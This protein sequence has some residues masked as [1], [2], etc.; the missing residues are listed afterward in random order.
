[1][2]LGR[3]ISY[4]RCLTLYHLDEGG[5]GFLWNLKVKLKRLDDIKLKAM[6]VEYHRTMH[7]LEICFRVRESHSIFCCEPK[8]CL[9][10]Y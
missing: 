8:I 3:I 7:S 10:V 1:M 2:A 6:G 4:S 5:N 9:L